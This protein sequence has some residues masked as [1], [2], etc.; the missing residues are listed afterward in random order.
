M[1]KVIATVKATRPGRSELRCAVEVFIGKKEAATPDRGPIR[2]ESLLSARRYLLPGE[3][4]APGYGLYSYLL[5][6]APP[7]D[8]EE[9]RDT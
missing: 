9:R 2:G 6:S 7:K 8:A 5:F 3:V 4:E 1:R